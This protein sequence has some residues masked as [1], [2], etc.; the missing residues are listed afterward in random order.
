MK[1]VVLSLHAEHVAKQRG[2]LSPWIEEAAY[3]P[4]WVEPDPSGAERRFRAIPERDNRIL[5]IV[6][7]ETDT[8]VRVITAFLDR[9]ARRPQ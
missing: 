4:D 1:P 3:Q 2:I 9:K 5:R 7:T 6:C 8:E